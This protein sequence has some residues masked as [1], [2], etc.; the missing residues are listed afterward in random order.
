LSKEARKKKKKK[1]KE[2]SYVQTDD[3]WPT[4]KKT[5]RDRWVGVRERERERERWEANAVRES[6]AVSYSEGLV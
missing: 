2:K 3:E 4:G 5:G 6:A 1:K